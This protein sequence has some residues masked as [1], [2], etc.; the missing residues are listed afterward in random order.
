[1]PRKYDSVDQINRRIYRLVKKRE[2]N[3]NNDKI[4]NSTTQEINLLAIRLE[5]KRQ[6]RLKKPIIET[7]KIIINKQIN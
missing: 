6:K 1:M 4:F 5:E 7:F 3:F 2:K